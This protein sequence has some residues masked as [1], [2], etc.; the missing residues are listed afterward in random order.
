MKQLKPFLKWAGGKRQLL[1]EIRARLPKVAYDVY[2]EPFVG[3][4]A[5][6]IDRLSDDHFK[7]DTII[8]DVNSDLV[9]CYEAIKSAAE[10]LIEKLTNLQCRYDS[11]A[12]KSEADKQAFYYAIRDQFNQRNLDPVTQSALL[13]CLNRTGFN[14]LYRVNKSGGFNVPI[15]RYKN[16]R[17]C[18][19]ENIRHLS[20]AFQKTIILNGDFQSTLGHVRGR[21]LFY[22]DPPYKPLSTSSSFNAYAKS[23][24]NDAAQIRLADF[25]RELDA[26]GH[27]WLLSNSDVRTGNDP[28]EF[29][30]DLYAGFNI[31]RVLADRM[32]N[33]DK[34]KRGAITELLISNF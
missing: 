4:G 16:P 30:D 24:F 18:N 2:V 9:A 23:S 26:A 21:G 10:D 14:G 3:G 6:F 1:P 13:I 20:R 22:F 15:G 28:S 32:I 8:N 27:L 17:I 7:A 19:A 31:Q 12:S 25:C 34:T 29:F 33:S 5:V 11:A